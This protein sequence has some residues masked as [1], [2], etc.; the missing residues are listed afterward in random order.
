[1]HRRQARA[2]GDMLLGQR[3]MP[4]VLIAKPCL[5]DPYAKFAQ[6]MGDAR[7]RITPPDI[8]DPFAKDRSVDESI[9]SKCRADR[10]TLEGDLQNCLAW[11]ERNIARGQG[12]N[13]VVGNAKKRILQVQ[14]IAGHV[15]RQNLTGPI[16]HVLMAMSETRAKHAAMRR[17]VPLAGHIARRFD[18]L[19]PVRECKQGCAIMV[20][21]VCSFRSNGPSGADDNDDKIVSPTA[22]E[23]AHSGAQM[24]T[25]QGYIY[26]LIRL[27]II[28]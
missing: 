26:C 10:R 4:F 1:M 2:I 15:H 13:I 28:G 9:I 20:V 17:R 27:R 8:R 14:D 11:N 16:C 7:T 24:A 22:R 18:E 6:Q 21:K 3:H 5:R 19:Q 12:L 23:F 25:M